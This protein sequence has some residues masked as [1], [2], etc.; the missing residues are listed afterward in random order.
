MER[1]G[2]PGDE[3]TSDCDRNS[4]SNEIVSELAGS[5]GSVA[6][7]VASLT[8]AIPASGVANSEC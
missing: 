8:L 5:V 2:P 4:G 7:V 6:A 3:A 1:E